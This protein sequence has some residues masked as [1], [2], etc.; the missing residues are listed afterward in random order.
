MTATEPQAGTRAAWPSRP[1]PTGVHDDVL[2]PAVARLRARYGHAV[3][4]ETIHL[5]LRQS[6]ERLRAQATVTTYLVVLAE[7]AASVRIAALARGEVS[8]GP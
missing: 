8:S 6:H 5:V 2:A 3:P 1:E 7:R 4:D